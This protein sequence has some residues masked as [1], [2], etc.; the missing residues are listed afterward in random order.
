MQ[1]FL[2]AALS[3]SLLVPT[4]VLAESGAL[5]P[6]KPAGVRGAQADTTTLLVGVGAAAVLVGVAVAASDCCSSS[7]KPV[8][9]AAAPT[10]TV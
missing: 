10:T 4:A 8:P 6:G 7:N 9:V 2:I 5:A 3:I 1:K